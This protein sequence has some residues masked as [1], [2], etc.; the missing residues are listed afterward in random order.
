MTLEPKGSPGRMMTRWPLHWRTT[1]Y[2][3]SGVPWKCSK[4]VR[5]ASGAGRI[6][7]PVIPDYHLSNVHRGKMKKLDRHVHVIMFSFHN[8]YVMAGPVRWDRSDR[9]G[10]AQP[11]KH[12]P[13][14]DLAQVVLHVFHMVLHEPTQAYG[15]VRRAE[16]KPDQLKVRPWSL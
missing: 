15:L 4:Q 9:E 1:C 13:G 6:S 14:I 10:D 5:S 3:S 2:P 11:G 12:Q 16:R 8:R 7:H